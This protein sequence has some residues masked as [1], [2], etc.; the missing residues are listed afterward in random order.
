MKFDTEGRIPNLYLPDSK[1]LPL[2]STYK[3]LKKAL[4][5][6]MRVA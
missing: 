1:T 2:Y 6:S 4:A 3:A 5:A